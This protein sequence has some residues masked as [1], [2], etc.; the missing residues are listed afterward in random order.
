VIGRRSELRQKPGQ[1]RLRIDLQQPTG[2]DDSVDD[3]RA[4]AS[5]GVA[6]MHP[7]LRADFRRSDVAF[8]RVLIDVDVP[9]PGLG[10]PNKLG[11][12]IQRVLGSIAQVA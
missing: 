2:A 3:R 11:P 9:V 8:D 7:V 4:P 12:T 5:L 1:I 6:D 10:V